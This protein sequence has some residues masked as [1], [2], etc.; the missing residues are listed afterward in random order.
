[1]I[2]CLGGKMNMQSYPNCK[3]EFFVEALCVSINELIDQKKDGNCFELDRI[4]KISLEK[5]I[6]RVVT[7][8]PCTVEA[9]IIAL[10]YLHR[11]KSLINKYTVHTLFITSLLI[12]CKYHDDSFRNNKFYAQ[13]GGLS[14]LILNKLELEFLKYVSFD[15]YIT[16]DEFKQ[17][18]H[19]LNFKDSDESC[20]SI[21]PSNYLCIPR[22]S[23]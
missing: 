1:M 8:V 22:N 14:H 19:I 10:I 12:A 15:C 6:T 23:I 17:Y 5:Y 11:V 2:K 4:P 3:L 20:Y 13:V 21:S 7:F 18:L 9:Y 16:L